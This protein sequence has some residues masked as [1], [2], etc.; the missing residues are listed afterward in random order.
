VAEPTARLEI[1]PAPPS[2]DALVDWFDR[3]STDLVLLAEYPLG[4]VGAAAAEF[5]RQV[6]NH[7]SEFEV[8]LRSRR[9]RTPAERDA[10]ALLHADHAWFEVSLD[11]LRWF[12]SIVAHDD[13]G[14]H[15]QALGQYGRVL[16]EALRR[17]RREERAVIPEPAADG[18][19]DGAAG[20]S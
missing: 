18:P 1:P 13:H 3:L 16:A 20:K 4:G 12:L 6:R 10:H 11:Q 7:L 15:R 14:G 5:D 19:G 9:P 2:F 17:H 8:R